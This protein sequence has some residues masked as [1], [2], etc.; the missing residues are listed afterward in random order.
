MMTIRLRNRTHPDTLAQQQGK[1]LTPEDYSILL[2]GPL[3][4]KAL[5]PNGQPLVV[6]L[7]GRLSKVQAEH[8]EVYEILHGLK[9]AKTDNR[10]L[11]SGSRRLLPPGQKR[12]RTRLIASSIIGAAD[13]MGTQPYCRLTAWTGKNL[14]KWEQLQPYLAEIAQAFEE[15]VPDRYAVQQEYVSRTHPDWVVPGTPFTTITVNNTYSTGVHKDSGDLAEGFSCLAVLRRGSY[16][17]GQLCFPEWRVAADL[18]D[19]DMLLMDAH[20]WHGNVE[21]KCR[22]GHK[23]MKAQEC[24]DCQAER[25]SV[26]AYYRQKMTDCGSYEEETQKAHAAAERRSTR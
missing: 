21:L 5:K 3:P 14:P 20:D 26:V 19:G 10:G 8:P 15:C 2:S 12:S 7:P 11:A 16:T 6:Y 17:G 9:S 22:H 24:G 23:E 25:I 13:P 4:V 18:H 1:H